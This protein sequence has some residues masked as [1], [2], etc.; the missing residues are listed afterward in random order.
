M[1]TQTKYDVC[2]V[3]AGVAGATMAAYLGRQGKSVAVVEQSWEE[4]DEIIG[5][6]YM[7]CA[8]VV[9]RVHRRGH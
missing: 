5:E 7:Q 3:G 8:L 6:R 1:D 2:I 9:R 4:P